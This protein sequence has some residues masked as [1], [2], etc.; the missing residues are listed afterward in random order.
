MFGVSPDYSLERSPLDGGII[1]GFES[2]TPG[3]IP[4][5]PAKLPDGWFTPNVS[6]TGAASIVPYSTVAGYGVAVDPTGG[7]NALALAR[8]S[9]GVHGGFTVGTV[10][11]QHK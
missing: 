7:N 6:S 9:H 5:Y 1:S 8:V 3:D 4:T 2:D 10:N 11:N